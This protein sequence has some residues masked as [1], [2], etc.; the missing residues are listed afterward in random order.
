MSYDL[1]RQVEDLRRAAQILKVERDAYRKYID[2]IAELTAGGQMLT[3][4]P[5]FVLTKDGIDVTTIE[6]VDP[7]SD[8]YS[9]LMWDVIT[10]AHHYIPRTGDRV[11]DLGAHYGMFSLYCAARGCQ[12][13]AYEPQRIPFKELCHTAEVAAEIGYGSIEPIEKAVWTHNGYVYLDKAPGGTSATASIMRADQ[14]DGLASQRVECVAFDELLNRTG[15]WWNC[16][17]MDIEGAEY[18]I[19]T[20]SKHLD[21]IGFL[22]VEIHNDILGT[23]PG[24]TLRKH[25]EDEFGHVQR[26]PRKGYPE[27]DVALFCR[28]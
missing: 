13:M 25:L 10:N 1:E 15:L 5:R 2:H 6:R 11:L 22:T 24:Q 8:S 14:N 19:L 7:R 23:E 26:L 12:V 17:K 21:R 16:V 20:R 4:L 3:V 18:E 9:A 27:Q 28:R